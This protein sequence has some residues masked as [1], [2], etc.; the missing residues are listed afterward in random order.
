MTADSL[1]SPSSTVRGSVGPI[2]ECRGSGETLVGLL[3][4]R[5]LPSPADGEDHPLRSTRRPSELVSHEPGWCFGTRAS[6]VPRPAIEEGAGRENIQRYPSGPI[7]NYSNPRRPES[8][9]LAGRTGQ[10]AREVVPEVSTGAEGR[11]LLVPLALAAS[12][13]DLGTD[14]LPR[15]WAF[16]TLG[17]ELPISG[18]PYGS[19]RT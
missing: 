4:Q 9:P 7:W 5:S 12:A 18:V 19:T 8:I 17:F 13:T 2:S 10:T 14:C 6:P 15:S 3:G 11:G 16:T 1:R